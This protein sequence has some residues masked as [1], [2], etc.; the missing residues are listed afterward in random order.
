MRYILFLLSPPKDVNLHCTRLYA[1]NTPMDAND[2]QHVCGYT[3][4]HN[5]EQ[6]ELRWAPLDK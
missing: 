3:E 5:V 2:N 6:R 1:P 4:Q